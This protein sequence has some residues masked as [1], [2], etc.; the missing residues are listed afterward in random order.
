MCAPGLPA[1]PYPPTRCHPTSLCLCK[2]G[3][4]GAR[5]LERGSKLSS[6]CPLRK[7]EQ[8]SVVPVC[9]WGC[10]R[11]RASPPPPSAALPLA[12]SFR[13]VTRGRPAS[14][15]VGG[16]LFPLSW[17]GVSPWWPTCRR[18][19]FSR[20]PQVL[21]QPPLLQRR[22]EPGRP[23]L[24]LRRCCCCRPRA[25][26]S[27]PAADSGDSSDTGGKGGGGGGDKPFEQ[28]QHA[29]PLG[30]DRRRM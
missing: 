27:R 3:S 5:W 30:A 13:H 10:G 19:P 28:K 8:A 21:L 9:E 16:A 20:A 1:P 18:C 29:L 2:E 7:T 12:K 23:L 22:P 4:G 11:G 17:Q 14:G 25:T 24:V 15:P 6:H 26:R